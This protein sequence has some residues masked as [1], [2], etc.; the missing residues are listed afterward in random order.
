MPTGIHTPAIARIIEMQTPLGASDH[1]FARLAR[2]AAPRVLARQIVSDLPSFIKDFEDYATSTTHPQDLRISAFVGSVCDRLHT[3]RLECAA[4]RSTQHS[5]VCMAECLLDQLSRTLSYLRQCDASLKLKRV[6]LQE[7]K[8]SAW[9]HGSSKSAVLVADRLWVARNWILSHMCRMKVLDALLNIFGPVE[10]APFLG[11]TK[12]YLLELAESSSILLDALPFTMGLVDR[13]CHVRDQLQLHDLGVMVAH[14]PLW[15]ILQCDNC[16]PE[17]RTVAA[18]I[19]RYIDEQRSI[20]SS[21]Q[22]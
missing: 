17:D 8:L 5:A 3:I 21:T 22:V 1:R 12:D 19:M 7:G 4:G 14:Y 6:R 11:D 20:V 13:E 18:G 2:A 9:P 16:P 10:D 15:T